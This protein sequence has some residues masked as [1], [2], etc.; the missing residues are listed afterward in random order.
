MALMMVM[1]C[2]SPQTFDYPDF[3]KSD[4]T[5]DFFGTTVADPW[6]WLE[7]P[8]SDMTQDWITAQNAVTYPYL[9]SLP[10]RT[11]LQER[12]TTLWDFPRYS[13]PFRRG[14]RYFYYYNDGLQN[15]FVLYKQDQLDAD[16]EVLID[17]NTFSEDGTVS[18]SSLAISDDGRYAA[19]AKSEGGSD[20]RE[21]FVRDVQ[22]GEDL[23]TRIRWVKFS[24]VS[25]DNENR[26]FYYSRFPQPAPGEELTAANRNMKL[27]YHRLGTSQDEDLLI[28]ERPDQPDW[29]MYGS[30][31]DDGNFLI[32]TIT[33]GTDPPEQS[34][35]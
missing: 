17:P 26:G 34:V 24:G 27:Y 12:L 14:D 13:S 25:W 20:W 16:G 21:F 1:A 8:N 4:V 30:V 18:M 19:Y 11:T 33:Q 29:G 6:R 15:Q 10:G 7:D 9:Q 3:P 35:L 5:D 22:T 32:I 28:Y 2:N 23:D 31:T